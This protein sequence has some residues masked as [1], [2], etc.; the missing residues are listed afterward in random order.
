M[1][2]KNLPLDV[3][4]NLRKIQTKNEFRGSLKKKMTLKD[5]LTILYI[6]IVK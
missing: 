6:A 5:I 4:N 3:L 2:L 1:Q